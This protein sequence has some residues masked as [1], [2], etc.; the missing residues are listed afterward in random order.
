MSTEKTYRSTDNVG[1][2]KDKDNE[3]I[4]GY[5]SLKGVFDDRGKYI[6][7][8]DNLYDLSK[9]P[10]SNKLF[11]EHRNRDAK[12]IVGVAIEMK[13]DEKGLFA[14]YKLAKPVN[15]KSE[16]SQIVRNIKDGIITS[17]STGSID[18]VSRHYGKKVIDK[19]HVFEVS[20]VSLP[21][22]NGVEITG[23]SASSLN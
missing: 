13:E 22:K 1:L 11:I 23:R 2:T 3:T 4:S 9:F 8:K 18:S 17:F 21:S 19:M 10:S 7:N 20:L 16:L 15:E 12:E 14:R 5:V 6:P